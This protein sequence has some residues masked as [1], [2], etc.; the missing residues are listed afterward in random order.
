MDGKGGS[1][2]ALL[3]S[4]LNRMVLTCSGVRVVSVNPYKGVEYEMRYDFKIIN[5]VL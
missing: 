4:A 1:R 3:W 5:L 2:A